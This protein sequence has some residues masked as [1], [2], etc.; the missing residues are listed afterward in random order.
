MVEACNWQTL[1]S[2]TPDSLIG[3]LVD[4][5]RRGMSPKT[6][7]EYSHAAKGFCNWCVRTRRLAANP[8][9]NVAKTQQVEKTYR[10]RALT[11]DEAARLLDVAGKRRLVYL[12]ALRTGLRRLELK[13]LQWGDLRLG[14]GEKQPHIALRASTT[15]ARRADTV[16]L[17]HDVAEAL[18]AAMPRGVQPRARVFSSIPKMATFKRDLERAGIP[19]VD[20]SGR[21]LDF[22]G[23][24]Y[25]CGTM[26]AKAGIAPRVAMEIMRHTDMRL[27]MN[28]YTDPSILNTARAVEQLADLDR[29]PEAGGAE[30][31]STGTDDLPVGSG[32]ADGDLKVLT[33]KLSGGG[34]KG[35]ERAIFSKNPNAQVPVNTGTCT[36]G[37]GNRTRVP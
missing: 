12:V 35:P 23:L 2:I 4:L 24:R 30:L 15:K 3:F 34:R 25:T 14:P 31:L 8:L 36:G 1:R 32:P 9:S 22:H 28:L 37:G 5:K 10:R 20:A 11:Q 26:L 13:N 27:T 21:V 16:P 29:Q 17:R 33:K 7:N 18:E 6:M 19:H